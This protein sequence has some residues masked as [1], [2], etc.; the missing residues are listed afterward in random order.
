MKEELTN[1]MIISSA[2]LNL[3]DSVQLIQKILPDVPSVV[4]SSRTAVSFFFK[5]SFIGTFLYVELVQRPES[6]EGQGEIRIKTD[7]QS[8]FTIIKDQIFAMANLRNIQVS[9]DS[10]LK[11]DSVFHVLYLLHPLVQEQYDI[12]R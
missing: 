2:K 9:I 1:H 6:P 8:V 7:N 5:S 10:D 3:D 12:A 4:D 11:D